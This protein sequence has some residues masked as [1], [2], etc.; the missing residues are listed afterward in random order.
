MWPHALTDSSQCIEE[1]HNSHIRDGLGRGQRMGC[2]GAVWND[3]VFSEVVVDTW[4][5]FGDIEGASYDGNGDR[6]AG[7]METNPKV[8]V[9]RIG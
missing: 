1:T 6:Y 5:S 3:R 7:G 9:L 4:R 2:E 8:N